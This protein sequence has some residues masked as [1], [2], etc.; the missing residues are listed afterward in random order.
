MPG[1]TFWAFNPRYL[2]YGTFATSVVMAA[3]K[4]MA[5]KLLTDQLD[6]KEKGT[7]QDAIRHMQKYNKQRKTKKLETPEIPNIDNIWGGP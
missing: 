4:D 6:P 1:Q 5:L 2:A 3:N 7:L